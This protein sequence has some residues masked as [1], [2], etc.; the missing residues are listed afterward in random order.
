VAAYFNA[1]YNYDD[2]VAL[3]KLWHLATPYDA[4]VA[5]S[6]RLTAGQTLP[7]QP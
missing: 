6:Q 3:A 1:G 2:A 7:I 4:K 5:G